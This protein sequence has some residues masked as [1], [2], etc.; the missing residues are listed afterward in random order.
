VAVIDGP[1][2]LAGTAGAA[3][4]TF[5][6]QVVLVVAAANLGGGDR[7][8]LEAPGRAGEGLLRAQSRAFAD[9]D[10]QRPLRPHDGW[11]ILEPTES[12]RDPTAETN[13][14]A[15]A[16]PREACRRICPGETNS[17]GSP[18]ASV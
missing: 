8:Q 5:A 6:V 9:G 18:L 2:L 13:A 10:P 12:A 11:L 15:L 16:E 1:P 7:R 4:A 14:V 3:L 17:T